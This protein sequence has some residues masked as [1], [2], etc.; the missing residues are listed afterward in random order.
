MS[1]LAHQSLRLVLPLALLTALAA[2]KKSEERPLVVPTVP[3]AAAAVT[4]VSFTIARID[5]GRQLA[6]DKTVTEVVEVF[7]PTDT[8]YA[9]IATTGAAPRVK[10]KAKWTYEDGQVVKESV[11]DIAPTGATVT[12]FNIAKPDGW[13]TGKYTVEISADEKVVGTKTFEVR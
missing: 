13:P 1:R 9:S 2:C 7:A 11:Q 8:I 6:A 5:L 4:P 12:E 10:L 3:P